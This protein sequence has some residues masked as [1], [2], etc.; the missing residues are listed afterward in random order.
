M[1]YTRNKQMPAWI[2]DHVQKSKVLTKIYQE[3][4]NTRDL[5]QGQEALFEM[6]KASKM[7]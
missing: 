2:T 7:L 5:N 3:S 6:K 4:T 1:Q